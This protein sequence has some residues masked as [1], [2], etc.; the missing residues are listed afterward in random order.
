MKVLVAGS[1]LGDDDATAADAGGDDGS[2]CV[3]FDSV[4]VPATVVQ[5]GVLRCYAP[6]QYCQSHSALCHISWTV[7]IIV[8]LITVLLSGALVLCQ[9]KCLEDPSRTS[10]K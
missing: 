8:R 2:Y 3:Q 10:P 7:S 6:R 4:R 1:W 5:R 9:G